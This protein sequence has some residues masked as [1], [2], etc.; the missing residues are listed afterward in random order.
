MTTTSFT[1][2]AQTTPSAA[3]AFLTRLNSLFPS[4]LVFLLPQ[5]RVVKVAPRDLVPLLTFLKNHT[6]REF[7]QLVD[8]TA[9][10]WPE[11]KNRFEIVYCLLSVRTATR[12]TVSL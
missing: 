9:I 7:T 3:S 6:G 10:D 1:S 2:I 11:R 8:L 12:L 5:E 4:T